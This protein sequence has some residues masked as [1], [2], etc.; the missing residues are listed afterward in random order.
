M[1]CTSPMH[2]AV[3]KFKDANE[4]WHFKSMH[5]D[6]GWKFN[7]EHNRA[8]RIV[9]KNS[10]S[11]DVEAALK[12]FAHD[13]MEVPCGNCVNCRLSYSR[14]WANRA[15]FEAEQYKYNWFITLT[16]DDEHIHKGKN[17]DN[18]T[19]NGDDYTKFIHAVRDKFRLDYGHTGIK[20]LGCGEYGGQTMRP[21]LHIILFNLPL[22]DLT[23]D[24]ND[25]KGQITHHYDSR[26]VP[27][28]FSQII[29]DC[30]PYGNILIADCNWNTSAYVSQYVLKKQKGLDGKIYKILGIMPPFLR[31]S[32]GLGLG[33][34]ETHKNQLADIPSLYVPREH[35]KPLE[36]GIPRYYRNKLKEEGLIDYETSVEE[37]KKSEKKARSL[38]AGKIKINTSRQLKEEKLKALNF[39]KNRSSL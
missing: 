18:F 14:D 1:A 21:H 34:Y 12:G 26:G 13:I 22:P 35:K 10:R 2:M 3:I 33:Y 23:I 17:G 27:Y 11:V 9:A 16:Y 4:A 8:Y 6:N 30:W 31:M 25:G 29:K 20:M 32:N 15:S 7:I 36:C 5:N 37:A 19:L 39:V 28:M 38:L 24:F